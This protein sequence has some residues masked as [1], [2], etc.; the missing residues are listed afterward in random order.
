MSSLKWSI[1]VKTTEFASL[2]Q[3][4]LSEASVSMDSW[5]RFH[6]IS[7]QTPK[8]AK[9]QSSRQFFALLGS[10]S[11]KA[12]SKMFVKLTLVKIILLFFSVFLSTFDSLV[13]C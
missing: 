3:I 11:E 7:H 13:I 6:Q 2:C 8:S 1:S 4:H 10:A 12:A 9:I 5:G